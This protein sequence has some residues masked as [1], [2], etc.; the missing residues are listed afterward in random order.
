[1]ILSVCIALFIIN[2]PQSDLLSCPPRAA[3]KQALAGSSSSSRAATIPFIGERKGEFGPR[4]SLVPQTLTNQQGCGIFG[5]TQKICVLA[6]APCLSDDRA[7]SDLVQVG[8]R[9][10]W[11]SSGSSLKPNPSLPCCSTLDTSSPQ[12]TKP[13]LTSAARHEPPSLVL[14]QQHMEMHFPCP[15]FG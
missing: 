9:S 3:D 8:I 13:V 7:N 2:S 1:M 11:K 14:S 5:P 6:S 4:K 10:S 12:G 15:P